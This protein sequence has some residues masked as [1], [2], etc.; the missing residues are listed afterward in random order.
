MIGE[1]ADG[2]EAEIGEYL[3]A[4][5]VLVLELALAVLTLEVHEIAAVA[6]HLPVLDAEAGTGLVQVDE[7]ALSLLGDGAQRILHQLA[8]LAL[9]RAENVAEDAPRMHADQH[10]FLPGNI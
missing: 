9:A 8:A 3:G 1:Q 5:A 6:D 4:Q 7:H 10:A 2:M